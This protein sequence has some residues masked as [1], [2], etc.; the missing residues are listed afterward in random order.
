MRNCPY[1]GKRHSNASRLR[2]HLRQR[3]YRERNIFIAAERPGAVGVGKPDYIGNDSKNYSPISS[4]ETL[5]A[6]SQEDLSSILR[7]I[8]ADFGP[9]FGVLTKSHLSHWNRM[10]E[11]KQDLWY[12]ATS[13]IPYLLNGSHCWRGRAPLARELF[14]DTIREIS[15]ENSMTQKT[16]E[17]QFRVNFQG[18]V[19]E[20]FDPYL[21]LSQLIDPDP[22]KTAFLTGLRLPSVDNFGFRLPCDVSTVVEPFDETNNQV[23]L[24]PKYS[25]VDLHTGSA[26]GLSTV[27]GDCRKIWLLYPPTDKNLKAMQSVDGQRAKLLRLAHQLEGGVLIKTTSSHAIFIP[28][29]CAYATFTLQGGYLVI[30]DFTTAKSLNAIASFIFYRLDEALPIE[31]REVCFD[32]FERCLDVTFA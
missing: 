14:M 31:A 13:S 18:E 5:Q 9:E 27:I 22:N 8:Q 25:F 10:S 28:V 24:T 16:S 11:H 2:K 20:A 30:K 3:K 15:T 12:K 7:G 19:D 4:T 26:D 1:C 29:G 6:V 17:T 23:N 21:V 32:W